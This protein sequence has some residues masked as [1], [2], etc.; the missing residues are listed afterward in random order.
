MT[1]STNSPDLEQIAAT[2]LS[3]AA[4]VE[5]QES[6]IK[7]CLLR[8]ARNGDCTL[9]QELIELWMAGTG[10]NFAGPATCTCSKKN[11]VPTDPHG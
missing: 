1:H 5:E 4:A 11:A 2:L 9:V 6:R 10:D 3:V 8:A 7:E